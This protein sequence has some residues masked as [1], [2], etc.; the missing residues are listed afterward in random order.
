ME[1]QDYQCFEK[2]NNKIKIKKK[3]KIKMKNIFIYFLSFFFIC[4][5]NSSNAPCEIKNFDLSNKIG[6]Q[7]K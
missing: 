6:L 7:K 4:F 3:N 1:A 5:C 2:K